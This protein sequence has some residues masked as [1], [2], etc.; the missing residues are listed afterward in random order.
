M[1]Q[2]IVKPKTSV[3]LDRWKPDGTGGFQGGKEET[4]R[5]LSGIISKLEKLQELLAAEQKHKV[6]IVLQAMDTGGKDGT[7][8]KVFEGVNPQGVRVASFKQPSVEESAH[9][10]LWRIHREVPGKGEIVIFN[11]SH[12]E[13]VLVTRVHRLVPCDIID[14]RYQHINDFER[15]LTDE[16]TTI[17]KFFLHISKAEQKRRI[18]DRLEEANKSWKF[19]ES[20]IA[21]REYWHQYKKAYEIVLSKTST[22]YAPWYIVPANH[23]WFRNFFV[24]SEIVRTLESLNMKYPPPGKGTH[25]L[26]IR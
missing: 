5:I 13:D 18:E 15:M 17:L 8:R 19:S 11:R 26:K 21:E 6:L 7:I 1:N 9:D 10:Y 23:K 2:F 24:A 20:D 12:Y 25:R 16:G 14:R 22:R 4:E 3:N